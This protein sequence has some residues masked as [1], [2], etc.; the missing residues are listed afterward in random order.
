[1]R[2]CKAD[3]FPR[4]EFKIV[5]KSGEERWVFMTAGVIEYEGKPGDNR[6]YFRLITADRR[7]AEEEKARVYEE[8]VRQ[9]KE[10]I[11]EEKG[12]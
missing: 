9:Y 1:M 3:S 6:N 7:Q 5:K 2:V 8:S 4:Y 10:R 11:E 12:I